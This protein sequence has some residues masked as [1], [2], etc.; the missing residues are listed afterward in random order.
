MSKIER[1]SFEGFGGAGEPDS[2]QKSVISSIS[3]PISLPPAKPPVS[4]RAT[5]GCDLRRNANHTRWPGV[6]LLG[7]VYARKIKLH[8]AYYE[9]FAIRVRPNIE[10][11][12]DESGFL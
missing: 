8:A 5:L 1:A 2:S 7:A 3:N 10:D 11:L 9:P 12:F 4:G 6:S